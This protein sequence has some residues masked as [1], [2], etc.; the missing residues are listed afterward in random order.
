MSPMLTIPT[1]ASSEMTGTCR[2][3]PAVI[4]VITSSIE[5]SGVHVVTSLVMISAT[6]TRSRWTSRD[7][8]NDGSPPSLRSART[9][10]RSD[11]IPSM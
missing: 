4:T 10:S 9:M 7:S 1:S 2:M 6:L 3:R 8:R 5:V 11:T